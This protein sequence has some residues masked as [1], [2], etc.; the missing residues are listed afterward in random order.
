[1]ELKYL[2]SRF[3]PVIN[4]SLVDRIIRFGYRFKLL[5]WMRQHSCK[6]FNDRGHD[7]RYDLYKFILEKE[8]L[9]GEIDYLEFGV[10]SGCS[11]RWWVEN[12]KS[13]KTRFVGFDTFEGLPEDWVY[14]KKGAFTTKGKL[15]DI[16]DN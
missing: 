10:A 14:A 5:E 4:H 15:P 9:D 11:L 13:Q 16:Q 12:N 1:M 7:S 6:D 2:I 3:V 8:R